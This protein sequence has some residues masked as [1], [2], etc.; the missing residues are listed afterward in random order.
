[1]LIDPGIAFVAP[2]HPWWTFPFDEPLDTD[3]GW[4]KFNRHDWLRDYQGFLE[5]FAGQVLT[6]PHSTKQIED[7]VGWGLETTAETLVLTQLGPQPASREEMEALRPV[8]PG[9]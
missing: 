9:R 5:F 8:Q 3:E 4:A 2:P 6:E 7:C 1:M